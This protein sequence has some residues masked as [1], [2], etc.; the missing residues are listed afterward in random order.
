MNRKMKTLTG[1]L[2]GSFNLTKTQ[3]QIEA[4]HSGR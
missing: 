4:M 3:K 2:A 1:A